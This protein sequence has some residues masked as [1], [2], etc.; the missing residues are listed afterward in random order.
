MPNINQDT[1]LIIFF[2]SSPEE[3]RLY[4]STSIYEIGDCVI[5]EKKSQLVVS[6]IYIKRKQLAVQNPK[7]ITASITVSPE[8]RTRIEVAR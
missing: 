7:P 2:P 8:L 5:A 6:N 4:T 1:N 3:R